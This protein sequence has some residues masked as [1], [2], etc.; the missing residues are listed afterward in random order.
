M[1]RAQKI[2]RFNLKIVVVG[3]PLTLLTIAVSWIAD[4]VAI[5]LV[6]FGILWA[7]GLITILSPLFVKQELGKISFDERDAIIEKKAYTIGYCTLWCIFIACCT[8]PCFALSSIPTVA[9]PVVLASTLVTVRLVESI[10]ILAQYGWAV[11]GEKS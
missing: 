11:R 9:L 4:Q 8:I 7:T 5:I 10:A 3:V 6:G 2:A 1:N